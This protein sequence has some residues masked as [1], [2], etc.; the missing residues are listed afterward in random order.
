MEF[1]HKFNVSGSKGNGILI[2]IPFCHVTQF[3]V[4]PISISHSG[5]IGS[6]DSISKFW[7]PLITFEGKSYPLNIWYRHRGRTLPVYR[8]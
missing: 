1:T 7:D 3:H 4:G 8:P 2:N 6:R 5:E